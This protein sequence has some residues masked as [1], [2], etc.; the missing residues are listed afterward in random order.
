[1]QAKKLRSHEIKVPAVLLVKYFLVP[2]L[3]NL[4]CATMISGEEELL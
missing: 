3:L 1:M 2:F 4:L